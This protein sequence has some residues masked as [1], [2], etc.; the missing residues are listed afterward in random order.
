MFL[1]KK[2]KKKEKKFIFHEFIN[3]PNISKERI[4][5]KKDML[6]EMLKSDVQLGGGGVYL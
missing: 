2:T 3:M 1:L 6:I 5:E 4:T